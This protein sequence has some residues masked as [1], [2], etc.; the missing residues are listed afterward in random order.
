MRKN[1]DHIV[2]FHV[3]IDNKKEIE[4]FNSLMEEWRKREGNKHEV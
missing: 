2:I 3:D 4:L 1:V